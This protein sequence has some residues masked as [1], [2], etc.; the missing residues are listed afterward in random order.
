MINPSLLIASPTLQDYL[1]D[2]TTGLPLNGGII[3]LYQDNS[4]DTLKNWYYQSGSPG[5][6]TYITL[7]NPL[8]LSSVGTIT[9]LNSNDTIPFFYPYSENDNQTPQPYYITVDSSTGQRQFDRQ[10][11]PFNP[12][13][14]PSA[15]STPTLRNYIVNNGFFEN[16]GGINVSTLTNTTTINNSTYYYQTLAPSQHIGFSMPDIIF[17]KNINGAGDNISFPKFIA[18]GQTLNNDITPEYYLNFTCNSAQSGETLKCIQLPISLHVETLSSVP[19]TVV[20]HEENNGSPQGTSILISILQFLGTGV[21][22]PIPILEQ[23]I[24][25]EDSFTKHIVSFVMPS[26]QNLALGP[27]GDDALY[28]QI[29]LPLNAT[30]S[31][32][33]AKPQIYIGNT[34]PDNNFDT[35]DE[36]GAIVNSPRT[37]DGRFSYNSFQPFGWVKCDDGSIG[38]SGSPATTRPATDTWPLY[39]LLWNAVGVTWAPMLDGNPYGSSAISDFASNR[40]IKLTKVLGRAIANIG[41]PLGGTGVYTLGEYFGNENV[42]LGIPNIPAHSH[43]VGIPLSANSTAPRLPFIVG[44][45]SDGH[46]TNTLTTSSVGSGTPFSIIQPTSFFNVFLKL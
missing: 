38:N 35:Y 13:N 44:N 26:A 4:R 16:A 29:G 6:Y 14:S 41:T 23:S 12:S 40:A 11:F 19:V 7:P 20:I 17:L 21:A 3:T 5:N 39:N 1:V 31:I 33:L 34:V 18:G 25:L 2:K 22:S 36:V 24:V 43:T 27:G 8:E 45:D 46:Q 32:N 28:L 9:D 30:C 10:N 42:G 15:L 37:G